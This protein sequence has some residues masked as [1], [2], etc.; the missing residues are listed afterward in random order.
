MTL[1]DAIR[2]A[3]EV[4]EIKKTESETAEIQGC[5]RYALKCEECASEHRQL[6]EWLRDY[7]RLKE[8]EPCEDAISRQAAIDANCYNCSIKANGGKCSKCDAVKAIEKLSS[9]KPQEKTGHWVVNECGSIYCSS[10][11]CGALYDKVYPG[12]SV[13]GKTIRVKSTF[14]PTCGAKMD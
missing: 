7:K 12:E 13:F 9:V 8:Q 11:G 5:D 10:C 6:A 2:H 1:E 14:C 4:A 3:E